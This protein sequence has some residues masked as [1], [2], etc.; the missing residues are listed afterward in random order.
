MPSG[1]SIHTNP[2]NAIHPAFDSVSWSFADDRYDLSSNPQTA[3]AHA[4]S[5]DILRVTIT[6][7]GYRTGDI[8]TGAGFSDSALNVIINI[9]AITAD[10]FDT[11]I[12]WEANFATDLGG[13]WT[14]TNNN[15]QLKIAL[16]S[17]TTPTTLI[18]T[19][20]A[21]ADDNG[22][23][24]FDLSNILQTQLSYA[25]WSSLLSSYYV[26]SDGTGITDFAYCFYVYD[27]FD[28][29]NGLLKTVDNELIDDISGDDLYAINAC[30][31]R[32]NFADFICSDDT[33]KFL[34]TRPENTYFLKDDYLQFSLITKTAL[35]YMK[36]ICYP[37][38][39]ETI[40]TEIGEG[41]LPRG[42]RGFL[43][44]LN[45]VISGY[46]YFTV[47]CYDD[48]DD[49]AITETLTFKVDN[50]D[51]RQVTTLFF[52]NHLGGIDT[53]SFI[54]RTAVI[55]G[56]RVNYYN[57]T[58]ESTAQ[59]DPS[60]EYEL[61]GKYETHEMLEWLEELYNS[62]RIFMI[63]DTDIYEVN[64][65]SNEHPTEGIDLFQ[66]TIKIKC[67]PTVIN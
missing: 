24:N 2:A 44:L 43:Y 36:I 4:N 6:G 67:Q 15:F 3:S 25:C 23:F 32:E 42:V 17:G 9:T 64:V 30:T 58:T 1:I 37:G 22:Y 19:T 51:Y 56:E 20:Y 39:V 62:H 46:D 59:F 49:S 63:V 34:T 66:P 65:T 26:F 53:Y 55:N 41:G 21:E 48:S 50:R 18:G 27:Q 11:P 47:T 8:I 29:E 38:A 7:H 10:D 61:I 28:D 45:S 31:H 40:Y 57:Q 12:T 60:K 35:T 14:R 5:S 52:E 16:Y 33:G 54:D 13:T